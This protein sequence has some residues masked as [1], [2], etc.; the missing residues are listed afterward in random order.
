MRIFLGM[1]IAFLIL[2]MPTTV[3]AQP[4]EPTIDCNANGVADSCDITQNVSDDCNLN[5]VPDECDLLGLTSSDCDS[6][7]I[8]DECEP[9]TTSLI[10]GGASTGDS[11]MSSEWMLVTDPAEPPPADE[12][13]PP[14]GEIEPA[15]LRLVEA[16]KRLGTRWVLDGYLI[17]ND[18]TDQDNL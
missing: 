10:I 9:V 13:P 14:P 18:P 7:G 15:I 16:Y 3:L 1:I 17:P 2:G 12:P 6:N 11:V 5:G 4:C 8:P